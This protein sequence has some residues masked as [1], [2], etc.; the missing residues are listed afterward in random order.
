MVVL[1]GFAVWLVI[2]HRVPLKMLPFDNKNELQVV[3]DMPEG[4]TLEPTEAAANALADYLVR[5]PEV[6]DVST[7]V[8]TSSP[9]DFNGMVRHYYLRQGPMLR[10]FA[11]TWSAR[12]SAPSRAMRIG[13][14]LRN[15]LHRIADAHGANIKI[16]EAPPGPPVIATLVAEVYGRIGQPYEE[17]VEAAPGQESHG[18]H[19]WRG[20]CGRRAGGSGEEGGFPSGSRQSHGHERNQ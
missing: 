9:M 16:V 10:T 14:R 6:T 13:L 19:P 3:I 8:G 12:N 18:G 17:L 2:S 11:S 1:L 20:G 4:T 15:D 5:V 7:Y